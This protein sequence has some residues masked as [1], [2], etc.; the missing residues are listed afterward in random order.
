MIK[1]ESSY[2]KHA[3]KG[4][5]RP[6]E[7]EPILVT[8]RLR[9]SRVYSPDAEEKT[10]ADFSPSESHETTQKSLTWESVYLYGASPEIFAKSFKCIEDDM[11]L[12]PL[13]RHGRKRMSKNFSINPQS[14]DLKEGYIA[15]LVPER[16]M[17][18]AFFPFS[19]KP[20]VVVGDKGGHLGF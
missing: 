12:S 18:V 9:S 13:L 2:R 10:V 7:K 15:R 4:Y 3:I 20:L 14:F 8:R 6:R 16:I 17:S 5:K 11:P 19:E 1:R